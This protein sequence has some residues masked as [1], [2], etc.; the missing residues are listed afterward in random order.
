MIFYG[1]KISGKW[2]SCCSNA[3]V[4]QTGTGVAILLASWY[5][6][7]MLPMLDDIQFPLLFSLSEMLKALILTILIWMLGI[8][9]RRLELRLCFLNKKLIPVLDVEHH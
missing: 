4:I 7:S 2:Y 1:S 6:I 9:G 5:I 3:L 8:F